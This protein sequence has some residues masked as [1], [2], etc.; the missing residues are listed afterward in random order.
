M[1][2]ASAETHILL[3]A[4]YRESNAAEWVAA[5][6]DDNGFKFAGAREWQPVAQA[7]S[8]SVAHDKPLTYRNANQFFH[9][10]HSAQAATEALSTAAYD[11]CFVDAAIANDSEQLTRMLSVAAKNT[12]SGGQVVVMFCNE[13]AAQQSQIPSTING[14]SIK[15]VS[16]TDYSSNTETLGRYLVISPTRPRRVIAS[17]DTSDEPIPV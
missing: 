13:E 17:V 10:A 8:L 6:T 1:T 4:P 3:I 12:L 5:L 15:A 2:N 16:T 9:V 7:V 11:S 14:V